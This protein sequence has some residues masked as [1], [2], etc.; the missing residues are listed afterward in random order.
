MGAL[1]IY[2]LVLITL[3]GPN[4]E[5][6]DINPAEIVSLR[7]TFDEN[8]NFH[9]MVN[10]VVRTVDGNFMGVREPCSKVR[11]LILEGH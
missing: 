11:Q 1:S 3:T 5:E 8:G 10:C 6:V 4:G 2:A 9:S 7:V